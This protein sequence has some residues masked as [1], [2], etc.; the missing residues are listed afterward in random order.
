MLMKRTVVKRQRRSN[1]DFI[2]H[3]LEGKLVFFEDLFGGPAL[4][5]IELHHIAM[6]IFVLKLIN[7]VLIAVKRGETGV[8]PH[9]QI[10]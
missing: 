10:K 5:T 2:L 9:T 6:T 3:E 7:A 8:H 1:R 4:R